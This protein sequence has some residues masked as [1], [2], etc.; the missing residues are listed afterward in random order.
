MGGEDVLDLI[1]NKQLSHQ[2][3]PKGYEPVLRV[4]AFGDVTKRGENRAIDER[5]QFTPSG[6]YQLKIFGTHTTDYLDTHKIRSDERLIELLTTT[7]GLGQRR[8]WFSKVDPTGR[9]VV[10]PGTGLIRQWPFIS[11]AP[12]DQ[13]VLRS[14]LTRF[15]I[16]QH[17]YGDFESPNGHFMTMIHPE[18]CVFGYFL[19]FSRIPSVMANRKTFDRAIPTWYHELPAFLEERKALADLKEE[20]SPFERLLDAVSVSDEELAAIDRVDEAALEEA[21]EAVRQHYVSPNDPTTVSRSTSILRIVDWLEEHVGL[22][23][24]LDLLNVPREASMHPDKWVC[25]MLHDIATDRDIE[26]IRAHGSYWDTRV[27]GGS[28]DRAV[29]GTNQNRKEIMNDQWR[30]AFYTTHEAVEIKPDRLVRTWYTHTPTNEFSI[31]H[32]RYR[33]FLQ[34]LFAPN[35]VELKNE[36]WNVNLIATTEY[37]ARLTKQKNGETMWQ[38]F[39]MAKY[40]EQGIDPFYRAREGQLNSEYIGELF[41]YEPNEVLSNEAWTANFEASLNRMG[42]S[43]SITTGRQT[44]LDWIADTERSGFLW[45][46]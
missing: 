28:Y 46:Q 12:E 41:D 24:A 37:P 40:Q 26:D 8:L 7:R 44:G 30:R 39:N 29:E 2:P 36:E 38:T 14:V 27:G 42:F 16:D 23:T 1:E 5:Y 10:T 43:E 22:E 9:Q 25:H 13:R 21:I 4:T 31:E 20:S 15:L 11:E 34:E 32:I 19:A 18:T 3:T 6:D 45:A 35:T 33:L 17:E